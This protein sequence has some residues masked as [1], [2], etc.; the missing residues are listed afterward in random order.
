[1]LGPSLSLIGSMRMKFPPVEPTTS[2]LRAI[3]MGLEF[4]GIKRSDFTKYQ[5][6]SAAEAKGHLRGTRYHKLRPHLKL[7]PPDPEGSEGETQAP[8]E[9][10]D[11]ILAFKFDL[12]K[13]AMK[14]DLSADENHGD[15]TGPFPIRSRA[16]HKYLLVMF[17]TG[18]NFIHIEPS[19]AKAYEK[20]IDFF[21]DK[22][23]NTAI[24]N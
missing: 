7:L 11:E 10:K 4:P 20:G 21:R 23:I 2:I 12:N 22:G 19:V 16:G 9:G 15:L 18:G 17:S 6:S 13:E 8:I 1:M 24:D 5:P 3:D 14:P